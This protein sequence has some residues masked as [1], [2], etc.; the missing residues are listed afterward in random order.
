MEGLKQGRHEE[1]DDRG[2]VG[3][4]TPLDLDDLDDVEDEGAVCYDEEETEEEGLEGADA[5]WVSM[6]NCIMLCG[7]EKAGATL[8][9]TAGEGR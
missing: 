1:S 2:G 3:L 4:T 8:R 9:P 6:R 5:V 7:E